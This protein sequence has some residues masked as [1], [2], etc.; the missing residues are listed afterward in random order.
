MDKTDYNIYTQSRQNISVGTTAGSPILHKNMYKIVNISDKIR[1]GELTDHK[2]E[3]LQ[4][5]HV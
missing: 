3:L 2:A 5:K 1:Y 4:T